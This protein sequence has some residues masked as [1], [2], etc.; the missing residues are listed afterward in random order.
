MEKVASFSEAK[1]LISKGDTVIV[2]VSGGADSVCLLFLLCEFRKNMD[3]DIVAVH[4]NHGIRKEAGRDA[5]FVCDLCKKWNVRYILV[6]KDIPALSKE[7]GM[8]EEE[9]GR[10]VRYDAFEEAAEKELS[11]KVGA[12]ELAKK[13]EANKNAKKAEENIAEINSAESKAR[14]TIKIAVAH[15]MCDN[16]ETVLFNLFRGS[17]LKGLTGIPAI[18]KGRFD[19]IR[20][21]LCLER[22][23]IEA[24]LA[25]EN[26]GFVTDA[27]NELNLYSRNRIRH[28]ILPVAESISS[29]VVKRINASGEI[30]SETED[31]LES[32][33]AVAF[34]ECYLPKE[35]AF[36]ADT[37]SK[38]HVALQRRVLHKALANAA[39]GAKDIGSLQISQ[40]LD[41]VQRSGNRSVDLAK[42]V[43]AKREYDRIV[44]EKKA[45]AGDIKKT[46]NN[47]ENKPQ[48]KPENEPEKMQESKQENPVEGRLITKTYDSNLDNVCREVF[49]PGT[50][51]NLYN[52]KDDAGANKYT[53]LVD[54]DKIDGLIT[55][56]TRRAGD[57]IMVKKE[58]G[59]FG[60][61]SLKQFMID[62]KIPQSVR[63]SVPVAAVGDK[64]LWLV[65]YRLS[66][67]LF[68]DDNTQKIMS[69]KYER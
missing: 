14:K 46:L 34:E 50:E 3:L 52:F 30:L 6:E 36:S 48:N 29:G 37:L 41:L 66:D 45:S 15:N 24:I 49:G 64:V 42:S 1:N 28:D 57:Y 56:R 63:D 65:G 22:S 16:A 38:Y 40:V 10:K 39:G 32:V 17:A 47:T 35:N 23:E 2:G 33:T 68:I 4:V 54:Y 25:S 31:Y 61:K 51:E 59:T 18:R 9:I 19:I 58:G 43:T 13:A 7:W 69:L 53:K 21:I 8:S 12:N 55:L 44:I 11:K 26:I 5:A 67:D 20:P 27:T 62:I 60:K